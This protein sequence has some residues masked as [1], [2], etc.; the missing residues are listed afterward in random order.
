MKIVDNKFVYEIGDEVFI[1]SNR[2]FGEKGTVT[3][4][5]TS[6]NYTYVVDVNGETICLSKEDIFPFDYLNS[7]VYKKGE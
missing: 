4:V 6:N 3:D 5:R 2:L 1:S 7:E